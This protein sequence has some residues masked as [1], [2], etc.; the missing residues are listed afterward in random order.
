MTFR[1]V[2]HMAALDDTS[3]PPNSL[4]AVKM[5]LD[6]K[7]AVIE[8]DITP[9]GGEDFLLVHDPDLESETTGQG[10]V[11]QCQPAQAKNYYLKHRGHVTEH[12]PAL[13][14]EVV[15]TFLDSPGETRL[16]LDYKAVF[17]TTHDEY[18]RRLIHLIEPL[19]ERVIVSSGADWHL[20]KLKRLAPWLDIGFD[21]GFYLDWRDSSW[22]VDPRMPPYQRGAYDYHD[23]HILARNPGFPVSTYLDERCDTLAVM[24]PGAS[25]WY[26]SHHLLAHCLDDGFNMAVWLHEHDIKLDAWTLDAD[27]P[28]AVANALRLRDAGVDLF[29]TNTPNALASLLNGAR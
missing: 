3:N 17:P 13:L 4:D 10:R 27:K 23:D 24:V 16:Q 29:T 18:L 26:V 22:K 28:V 1:I 21:I 5:S 12:P 8:V 6:A 25:T 11:D 20:R 14:S 19:G 2:H 7:A 9:L 15:K